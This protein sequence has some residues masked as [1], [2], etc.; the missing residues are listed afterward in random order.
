MGNKANWTL[1]S[2][3]GFAFVIRQLR[4]SF[5]LKVFKIT[6]RAVGFWHV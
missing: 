4:V 6:T 5:A 2:R 1:G 3:I